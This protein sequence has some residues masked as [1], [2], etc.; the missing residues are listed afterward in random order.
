MMSKTVVIV[1]SSPRVILPVLSIAVGAE[2]HQ[3]TDKSGPS[4]GIS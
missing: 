4:Y 1:L 3:P 2:S